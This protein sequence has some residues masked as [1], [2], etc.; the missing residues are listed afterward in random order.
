[1]VYDRWW[2]S[3]DHFALTAGAGAIRNPGRYLVLADSTG[4]TARRR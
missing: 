4:S 3:N 2:F 1:M